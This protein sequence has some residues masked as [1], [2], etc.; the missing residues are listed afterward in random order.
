MEK[1]REPSGVYTFDKT[2][3]LLVFLKEDLWGEV[4]V[5]GYFRYP[6]VKRII[7]NQDDLRFEIIKHVKF[8]QAFDPV[9]KKVTDLLEKPFHN[10][11]RWHLP[12]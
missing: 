3:F 9:R 2:S 12:V 7:L 6:F 1:T 8:V 4:L 11:D 10:K 5:G